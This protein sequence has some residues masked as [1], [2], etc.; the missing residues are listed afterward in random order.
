L[1]VSTGNELNKKK[2]N[3]GKQTNKIKLMV[4]STVYGFENDLTTIAALLKR[5]GY[6]VLNSHI[7]T[8]KAS[9]SR[10]N[11]ENC[12]Q[13]VEECDLFLGII[14]PF[15]GSGNIGKQN[16]T[17]E[18]IKLAIKMEKPCWFLVHHDVVVMR[19]FLRQFKLK[20]DTVTVSGIVDKFISVDFVKKF[21]INKNLDYRCVDVYDIVSQNHVDV[22]KRTG[23]WVQHFYTSEEYMTYIITQFSNKYFIKEVLKMKEANNGI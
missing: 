3:M 12:L 6:D 9:P 15:Y 17:V 8:I 1:P 10:S 14:R 23:N 11:L 16:I 13:T 20:D 4:S 2:Y 22:A 21:V 19:S 5:L 18:E 7:G